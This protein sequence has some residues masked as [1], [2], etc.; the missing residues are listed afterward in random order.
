[1]PRFIVLLFLVGV[2]SAINFQLFP[3]V[4]KCFTVTGGQQYH[5]EYVVSGA[6]E[7]AT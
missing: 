3:G 2:A 1:M 4:D 5:V 6:E 7:N